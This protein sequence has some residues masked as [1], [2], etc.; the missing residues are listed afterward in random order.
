MQVARAPYTDKTRTAA[1]A[2]ATITTLSTAMNIIA[3]ITNQ[4]EVLAYGMSVSR[5]LQVTCSAGLGVYKWF[6]QSGADLRMKA[7][8]GVKC[9]NDYFQVLSKSL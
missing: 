4:P 7:E 6:V 8:M 2:N 5:L 3:K 9:N 1:S